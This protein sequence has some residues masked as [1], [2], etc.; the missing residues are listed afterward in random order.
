MYTVQWLGAWTCIG[1]SLLKVKES[2]IIIQ[3]VR[4]QKCAQSVST[5][6]TF[7]SEQ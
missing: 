6:I 2:L 7:I 1:L 5:E 4:T 3:M